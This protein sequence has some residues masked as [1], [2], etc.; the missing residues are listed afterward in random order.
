MEWFGVALC[1]LAFFAPLL[2]LPVMWLKLR[3]RPKGKYIM[4]IAV[5]ASVSYGF[6]MAVLTSKSVL[7]GPEYSS[8][9]FI[10]AGVNAFANLAL[11]VVA[12]VRKSPVRILLASTSLIISVDWF[13]VLLINAI[14]L[15]GAPI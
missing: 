11:S 9:L 2:L 7:L 4:G 14:A 1:R 8:R 3:A 10:T 5:L 13:Y 12:L 6:L 15:G